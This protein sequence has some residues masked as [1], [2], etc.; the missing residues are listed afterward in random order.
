MK[1]KIL[2]TMLGLLVICLVTAAYWYVSTQKKSNTNTIDNTQSSSV[3]VKKICSDDLIGRASTAIRDNNTEA[4]KNVYDEVQKQADYLDDQNC[5]Y[6]A[7]WY[8]YSI[9]N[10]KNA[11]EYQQRLVK[12]M[13]KAESYSYSFDPVPLSADALGNAISVAESSSKANQ[14]EQEID[15]SLAP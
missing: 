11:R 3:T 9:G 7:A 15:E 13:L 6:I 4:L 5:T 14:Q 2:F 8:N 10:L 1:R 12:L